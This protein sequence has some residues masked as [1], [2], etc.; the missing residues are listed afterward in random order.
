MAYIEFTAC[1]TEEIFPEKNI[2][3]A[4]FIR[5]YICVSGIERKTET[6]RERERKKI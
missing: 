6:D 1:V 2:K 3:S 5:K 4:L